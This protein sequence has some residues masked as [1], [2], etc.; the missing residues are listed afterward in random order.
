MEL[1][2]HAASNRDRKLVLVRA[3]PRADDVLRIQCCVG[4]PSPWAA[5]KIRN[6]NGMSFTHLVISTT[7]PGTPGRSTFS[8]LMQIPFT[9]IARSKE[10]KA[11]SNTVCLAGRFFRPL[12]L[13]TTFFYPAG[14]YIQALSAVL[15]SLSC[16]LFPQPPSLS[17]SASEV[18]IQGRHYTALPVVQFLS[19]YL[20]GF[21]GTRPQQVFSPLRRTDISTPHDTPYW[22]ST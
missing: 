12:I 19:T 20:M 21:Q 17:C 7:T 5:C 22:L 8:Y 1:Y 6:M 14:P 11:G 13:V 9:W 15:S 18:S 3:T 10:Y 2:F 4:F 16:F